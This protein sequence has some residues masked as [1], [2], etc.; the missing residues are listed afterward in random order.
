MTDISRG[1]GDGLSSASLFRSWV[2]DYTRGRYTEVVRAWLA[3]RERVPAALWG[4]RTDVVEAVGWSLALTKA[5]EPYARFRDDLE[6]HPEHGDL[7]GILDAWRAIHEARYDAGLHGARSVRGT[8]LDAGTPSRALGYALRV[9]GVALLRM[10]RYVEAESLTRSALDLFQLAGDRLNVSHCATNL[11]LILNA[12]GELQAARAALQRSVD[13]LLEAGAAD[14]RLAL[15]RVNLAVVEL[16]LGLVESARSLFEASLATF[17][18][19]QLR[20]EQITALNGLGHCARALGRFDAALAHHRAALR[21]TGPDLLRQTGLCHEFLGQVHF[22]RGDRTRAEAHYRRALDIAANIAP[23][24]DLMLEVAWHYGE[25]L[26]E[27]GRVD[28]AREHV[29]RAESL[30]AISQER[31]ELGCVQRARA[32]LLAATHDPAASSAFDTAFTTLSQT[33]R[34][35]ESVLTLLVHADFASA[36]GDADGAVARLEHARAILLERLPNSAWIER[37]ETALVHH[38]SGAAR[39][40]TGLIA[41]ARYGV[42]TRDPEMLACSPICRQSR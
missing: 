33:G 24:G 41:E 32:R 42:V 13:A 18:A 4:E 25:L 11:G 15:A 31:R 20:S 23:D 2:A 29:E 28:A 9:E 26:A 40:R 14:E 6:P 22:D 7:I 35:F 16:H 39:R 30:C 27:R 17:E 36:T 1:R 21:R 8:L 10:G 34:V 5:W 37:V 12:R 38:R 3:T 19:R